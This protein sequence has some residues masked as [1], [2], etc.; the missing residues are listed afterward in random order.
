[1]IRNR[2][3]EVVEVNRALAGPANYQGFCLASVLRLS[4]SSRFEFGEHEETTQRQ[5]LLVDSEALDT[6][7]QNFSASLD[8]GPSSLGDPETAEAITSE[9]A[10][11]PF[12]PDLLGQV[13]P[14]S[15]RDEVAAKLTNYRARRRPRE[16][17]YPSMRLKFGPSDPSAVTLARR[18]SV[19]VESSIRSDVVTTAAITQPE[20]SLP[21][22]ETSA[23]IIEFPRL[24]GN[25]LFDELAE[26]VF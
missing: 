10:A 11:G 25:S 20:P 6:R 19:N 22:G 23:Q 15:W 21:Q 7:E 4:M 3:R 14:L 5:S 24:L 12:Q 13:G 26:P 1:M 2:V 8:Q 17:R 18:Q 9:I 16:P